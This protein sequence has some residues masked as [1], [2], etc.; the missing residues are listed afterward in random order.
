MKRVIGKIK[1]ELEIIKDSIAEHR[2]YKSINP[3]S[4]EYL[5]LV[6]GEV[7][8]TEHDLI[9]VQ[10]SPKRV[11]Y[12]LKLILPNMKEKHYQTNYINSF[13][14][15]SKEEFEQ[16][17]EDFDNY[18][19]LLILLDIN[20]KPVIIWDYI[21]GNFS[22]HPN[23]YTGFIEEENVSL[24]T[25]FLIKEEWEENYQ[26]FNYIDFK[27]NKLSTIYYFNDDQR[28]KLLIDKVNITRSIFDYGEET[29]KF[30][31]AKGYKYKLIE[32]FIVI[33]EKLSTDDIFELM[34][35]GLS[36]GC[37]GYNGVFYCDFYQD[38]NERD[39]FII[40]NNEY[41]IN[42]RDEKLIVL[43]EEYDICHCLNF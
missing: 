38:L 37:V 30:V 27:G 39:H 31:K 43:Y 34:V 17:I 35:R 33:N 3:S 23:Y 11:Q 21:T 6:D 25:P 7:K 13:W 1:E 15:F 18:Y 2:K 5:T 41:L 8:S 26:P 12:Y 24:K 32:Q 36:D 4:F 29:I 16:D 20:K 40:K 10:L 22:Y 19:D 42:I 28:A 9:T 14:E